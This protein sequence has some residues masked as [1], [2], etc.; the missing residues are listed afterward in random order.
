MKY[1]LSLCAALASGCAGTYVPSYSF[2]QI[3]AIN[4]SGGA[5]DD[6]G[7]RVAG[8]DREVACARVVNNGICDTRFG[9]RR[10]PQQGLELT[11]THPDGSRRNETVAQRVPAYFSSG[12]PLQVFVEIRADG[13]LEAYY[14]QES[15]IED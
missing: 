1:L 11:W 15:W 10:Y 9:K 12:R 2:N 13:S 6:V 3:Q 8:S 5:I 14:R 4:L 7:L